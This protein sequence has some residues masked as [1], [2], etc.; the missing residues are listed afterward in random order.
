MLSLTSAVADRGVLGEDR[1]A[2]LALEVHRVHDALVDV[3]VL[4]EGA[5]LP[6]HGVDERGLAVVDVGD[7][8]DVAQVVAGGSAGGG[9]GTQGTVGS[10]G[11]LFAAVYDRLMAGTEDAG[12]RD[13]RHDL[14]GGARGEVLE[15]GAGTGLNFGHYRPEQV[16]RVV[17]TEPDAHMARRARA[18][19][20]APRFRRGLRGLRAGPAVRRASFD[21]VVC[22]LVLCTVP[23][24]PRAV[25]E[26]ERVLRPGGK[27]LFLEH[28]RS[29]QPGT[30]RWQYRLERPWGVLGAGCHP[31]RDTL[32][33]IGASPLQVGGVPS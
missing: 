12:L 25:A 6:Q 11:R 28:V 33:L 32:A 8:G 1:D 10:M 5:G 4:A 20:S 18:A 29:E 14:V 13:A 26:V 2:L 27:L 9:Q 7:D 30:A 23:D 3:L 22:T 17:A 19:A 16:T 15:I 24:P 21:T 31:N